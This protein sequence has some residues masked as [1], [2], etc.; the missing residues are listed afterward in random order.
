[1]GEDSIVNFCNRIRVPK[2][3]Q[4]F[5]V[6]CT[7]EHMKIEKAHEMSPECFVKWTLGL[8]KYFNDVLQVSFLIAEH[9]D[10]DNS[11]E[12]KEHFQFINERAKKVFA[13]ERQVTGKILIEEGQ[14]PGKDFGE[15][16]FQRR[17]EAFKV[18]ETD[19][20]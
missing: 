6:L 2:S 1:M 18:V 14:V 9:R 12:Q 20:I 7:R 11:K 13:V 5:G 15:I 19:E 10:R 4:N 17:V 8:N 3:F 16:L